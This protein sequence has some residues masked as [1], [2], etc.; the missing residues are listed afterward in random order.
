MISSEGSSIGSAQ[1][2]EIALLKAFTF[3]ELNR[4]LA[5]QND[6]TFLIKMIELITCFVFSKMYNDL[7]N[8]KARIFR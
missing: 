8:A 6:H 3:G 1:S 2:T 7:I 4:R 5:C